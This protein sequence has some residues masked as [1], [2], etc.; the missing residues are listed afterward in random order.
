M[1][2]QVT[3]AEGSSETIFFRDNEKISSTTTTQAILVGTISPIITSGEGTIRSTARMINPVDK[4]IISSHDYR[5]C[6][7]ETLLALYRLT[8]GP[9]VEE[10]QEPSRSKLNRIFY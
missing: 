2:R 8:R 7:D 1:G 5:V 6:M 9:G 10:I 4:S 3:N